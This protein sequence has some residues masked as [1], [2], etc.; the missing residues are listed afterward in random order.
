MNIKALSELER[1]YQNALTNRALGAYVGIA[2]LLGLI[3]E[4]IWGVVGS[5][6]A[7]GVVLGGGLVYCGMCHDKVTKT[8]R[9]LDCECY[10]KFG[11]AYSQSQREIFNEKY[12][13][14]GD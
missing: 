9:A 4:F 3:A 14:E 1:S 5:P 8:L 6:V 11:K 10:A 7:M 12:P 2:G 13:S